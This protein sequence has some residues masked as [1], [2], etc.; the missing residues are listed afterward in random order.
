[1]FRFA[2]SA[3]PALLFT[4]ICPVLES[5][6][7]R[8]RNVNGSVGVGGASASSP[9]S[10]NRIISTNR[11]WTTTSVVSSASVGVDPAYRIISTKAQ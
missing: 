8:V 3:L 9:V 10:L 6:S 7:N 11:Q 1:M 2:K 5:I 4:E